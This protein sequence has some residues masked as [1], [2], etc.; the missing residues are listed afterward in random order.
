[1]L[2]EIGEVEQVCVQQLGVH[3]VGLVD[4]R[5]RGD[6]LQEGPGRGR[7]GARPGCARRAPREASCRG[8]TWRPLAPAAFR[9]LAASAAATSRSC[10]A[11][12]EAA[13]RASLSAES[14]CWRSF[15]AASNLAPGV[16]MISYIANRFP[17]P[18]SSFPRV[19]QSSYRSAHVVPHQFVLFHFSC[20][21]L[22]GPFL[23]TEGWSN[24]NPRCTQKPIH[25]PVFTNNI[26]S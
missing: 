11:V 6:D 4:R 12:P 21:F 22:L 9:A 10:A 15:A 17:P 20:F 18:Y 5:G 19:G 26:R 8:R 1:M 25:I 24:R 7:T 13:A 16:Q 14:N 3:G 23:L 2:C